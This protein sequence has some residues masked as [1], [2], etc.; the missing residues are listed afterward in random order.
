MTR[1]FFRAKTCIFNL[2]THL[3]SHHHCVVNTSNI[4]AVDCGK[5]KTSKS[6]R[7]QTSER[8]RRAGKVEHYKHQEPV[9]GG[10]QGIQKVSAIKVYLR[11]E[12]YNHRNRS[13]G[14]LPVLGRLAGTWSW[15]H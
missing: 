1:K 8:P 7:W 12:R 13:K 6:R 3:P 9:S 14:K 4:Y 15:K 2:F 5:G 10:R 11:Q